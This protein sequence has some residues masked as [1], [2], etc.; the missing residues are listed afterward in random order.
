MLFEP[1]TPSTVAGD[2][3]V[4]IS[5]TTKAGIG[6]LE[7]YY[8]A[9]GI[10]VNILN[11]YLNQSAS[12]PRIFTTS[13][14]QG[15]PW[16]IAR[17]DIQSTGDFQILFE[18]I[19]GSTGTRGDI[20]LDEIKFT[21]NKICPNVYAC[22][23]D[24][25]CTW[26][27]VTDPKV[28]QAEWD[29]NLAG[30]SLTGLGPK[31]DSEGNP[32]GYYAFLE[33]TSPARIG[34]R[35]QLISQVIDD[36]YCLKFAYF[37]NGVDAGTINIYTRLI[38]VSATRPQKLRWTLSGTQGNKWLFAQ[39]PLPYEGPYFTF[40]EGVVGKGYQAYLA[41]DQITI[42]KDTACKLAPVAAQ[43]SNTSTI[44]CSF[45]K[46]TCGWYADTSLLGFQFIR[47]QGLFRL[48]GTGPFVDHTIQ[49]GDG[50][51]MAVE[52][53]NRKNNDKARLISDAPVVN[54]TSGCFTFWYHMY[55][56]SVTTLN[57]Y[58][59]KSDGTLNEVIWTKSGNQGNK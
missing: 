25:D 53:E 32:Q 36:A 48:N 8:N 15:R 26:Q 46:D 56:L 55:G 34:D 29:V 12:K 31:N 43:P 23:F 19:K 20:G 50:W 7:F 49:S 27:D 22:D 4:L 30:T 39:V 1:S 37:M 59:R 9:N 18:A 58:A 6:C 10:N 24:E 5:P 40:V 17:R 38:N 33:P 47:K 51:Y 52:T 41:I 16:R 21:P 42:T 44:Q 3:A 35:A 2:K 45:E 28:V 11:V 54:K 14:D 57:I 13:G